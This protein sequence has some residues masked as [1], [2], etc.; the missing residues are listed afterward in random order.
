MTADLQKHLKVF[1]VFTLFEVFTQSGYSNYFE[2]NIKKN[3][4]RMYIIV[5]SRADNFSNFHFLTYN[6]L[7]KH[8]YMNQMRNF[9]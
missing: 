2:N 7:M 9:C 4:L 6:I 1:E 8:D 3:Q 5:T